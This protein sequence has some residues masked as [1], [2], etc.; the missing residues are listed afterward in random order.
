MN[1]KI[2]HIPVMLKEVIG[3][4][5]PGSNENFIDATLG[6]GGHSKEILEKTGPAGILLGVDLSSEAIKEASNKLKDFK[7][8]IIFIKRDNFADI[9]NIV[10]ELNFKDAKGILFDL[11]LSNYLLEKSNRGF[12]FRKEEI[13]DMRFSEEMRGRTARDI[14]NSYDER[15]LAKIFWE[16]GEERFAR[17]IAREIVKR[18]KTKKFETTGDLVSAILKAKPRR[19]KGMHPA[20][21]VFQALR[22]SVNNEL[23]NLE[24]GILG[25]INILAPAGRI[26]VISFH[27]LE[28]RIVKNTFKDF[29]AKGVLKII[30]KKPITPSEEEV[31]E[32][33]KSRSGKLRVAEKVV[34]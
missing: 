19:R 32:N 3:Y 34:V 28:D 26:A 14:L 5:D 20:R 17:R 13:L 33:P 21:K 1:E 2:T 10:K 23:S 16:L 22:I 30:T 31:K 4:L 27:S 7:K 6:G 29:A 18:R 11:G 24:K 8:R 12:S 25:A 15:E 9:E